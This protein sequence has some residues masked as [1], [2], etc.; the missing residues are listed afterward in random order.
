[1]SVVIRQVSPLGQSSSL[2]HA[3]VR[4]PKT[5]PHT[6]LAHSSLL[7]H[8]S[9]YGLPSSPQPLNATAASRHN[10]HFMPLVVATITPRTA[11]CESVRLHEPSLS[12]L[13]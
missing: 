8:G 13:A 4:G 11:V 9:P 12:F 10:I 6:S 3:Q 1:M 2:A 5:P 7:V